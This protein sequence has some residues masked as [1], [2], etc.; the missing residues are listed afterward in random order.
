MS[1][2]WCCWRRPRPGVC[3]RR[4]CSN[5][6]PPRR[7]LLNVDFWNSR[8][9]QAG[10]ACRRP[11]F[12]RFACRPTNATRYLRALCR[13]PG[14]TF[15]DHAL[16]LD[17][18]RASEV[19]RAQ[20]DMSGAGVLRARGSRQSTG[21]A[22]W[23]DCRAVWRPR[24]LREIGRH[25][26]LA[27]RRAGL[28]KVAARALEWLGD[29]GEVGVRRWRHQLDADTLS[30]SRLRTVIVFEIL[31]EGLQ[32]VDRGDL[33]RR[34]IAEGDALQ[35]RCSGT[36][37]QRRWHPACRSS[38]GEILAQPV[39]AGSR[40][41]PGNRH[42]AIAQHLG[43]FVVWSAALHRCAGPQT[44]LRSSGPPRPSCRFPNK[45]R[46]AGRGVGLLS[47]AIRSSALSHCFRAAKRARFQQQCAHAWCRRAGR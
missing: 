36:E 17:M 34:L 42:T 26:P 31:H 47:T 15:R 38:W 10:P 33:A 29:V 25:E 32:R 44:I 14:A 30:Q 23:S 1:A 9:P 2:R 37:P 8:R 43:A 46:R 39:Q 45:Y 6:P 24:R 19:D 20:C 28:G 3:R 21:P 16:G 18:A 12:P 35:N 41:W 40:H 7:M 5:S 27:D 22:R 11:L 4:P 13:N